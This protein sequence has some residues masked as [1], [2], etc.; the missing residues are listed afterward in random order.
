MIGIPVIFLLIV[1]WVFRPGARQKYR[2][3]AN[4][5]FEEN[6]SNHD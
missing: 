1:A 5:P 3:D 4:I 2:R 6:D